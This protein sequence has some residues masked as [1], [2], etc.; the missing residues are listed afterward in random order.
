M[1]RTLL[2]AGAIFLLAISAAQAAGDPAAGKVKSV[3]APHAMDQ[4]A[5]AFRQILHWQAK[6]K[7][8]FSR[9]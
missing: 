9:H 4:Q 1:T 7:I 3:A 5:K 6:V 2:N 8:N